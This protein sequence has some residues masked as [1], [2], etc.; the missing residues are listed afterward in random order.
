MVTGERL[1]RYTLL[2]KLA[3]GGMAEVFL[4]RQD[5]PQGFAKTVVIK[6]ILGHLAEDE[7]FV[8]MFLNEARLA[9]LINHP[10][11]VSIYELGEDAESG[12]FYMVMEYIDGGN[13]KRVAHAAA[14]NRRRLPIELCAKVLADAAAGLDF[15]HNLKNESGQ[16]LE[17]VH[18]D[19]SP[20]NILITYGGQVKVVDFGIAKASVAEGRT[21]TGQLKGKFGYMAPEQALGKPLDRRADVWALGVV[22]YW[23]CTGQKPFGGDSEGAIIQKILYAT[24]QVPSERNPAV[25]AEMDRIILTA[26]AKDPVQRYP[27]ARALQTDLERWAAAAGKP[28]STLALADFMNQQFPEATDQDRL[29]TRAIL[30]GDFKLQSTPSATELSRSGSRSR[31]QTG[32]SVVRPPLT[33]WRRAGVAG[34]LLLAIVGVGLGWKLST[35]KAPPPAQPATAAATPLPAPAVNPAPAPAPAP[36]PAAP[37]PPVP[38]LHMDPIVI[39]TPPHLE[40]ADRSASRARLGHRRGHS[41]AAPA[42][43]AQA[44]AE[45]APVPRG[46]PGKLAVRVLPWAA[47]YVD[48]QLAGTTPFEPVPIAA[49]RHSVR[50]VNDEIHAERTMTVDIKSGETFTLKSKLE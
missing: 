20:E 42:L 11:V 7:Q 46:P 30:S 34:G 29:L 38:A 26:L 44:P 10:N 9:A 43:P 3:T 25:D 36:T 39:G 22:L 2:G 49:G 24:P 19:V 27:N 33:R 48:G 21:R 35:P 12:S 45:A 28:V 50:L 23:L 4:A 18:R 8:Q 31:S 6:K 15:A 14:R 16:P 41:H 13:L 5:G 32:T 47:V 40:P 1:G 37:L 17:I